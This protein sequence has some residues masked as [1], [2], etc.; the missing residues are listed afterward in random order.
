MYFLPDNEPITV[1]VRTFQERVWLRY[2]VHPVPPS[3]HLPQLTQ[4]PRSHPSVHLLAVGFLILAFFGTL[5]HI[6]H[7]AD[8]RFLRLTH[9]PGT[10]ASAVSLGAQTGV[11]DV[12]AGRHAEEDLRSALAHKRFRMNPDT[13]RI[14]MD[15]EEEYEVPDADGGS[16][17]GP[18]R[19][20]SVIGMLQGRRKS[21]RF[22][23]GPK[24]P[25]I[26]SGTPTSPRSP[27]TP[28][29]PT[30]PPKSPHSPPDA[31]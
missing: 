10:I 16:Q 1:Q 18:T 3:T 17:Q 31:A 4:R 28:R 13:M 12:L 19:R 14:I 21:T 30:T 11:G 26:N 9:L 29:M 5:V 7:R 24:L 23:V 2:V 6:V 8:R 25:N 27:H 22:S 20:M 15:T